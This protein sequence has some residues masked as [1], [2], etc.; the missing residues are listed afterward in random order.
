MTEPPTETPP[1]PKAPAPAPGGSSPAAMVPYALPFALFMALTAA[2]GLDALKP[3]YPLV[4][5]GKAAVVAAALWF[6]RRTFLQ[7][8]FAVSPLA[9]AAGVAGVV[10][11]VGLE[12]HLPYPKPEFLGGAGGEAR[13]GFDPFTAIADPALRW[14]FI[15]VRLIGMAALVPL[16]E[17]ILW[18]GLLIRYI[19]DEDFERVEPGKFSPAAFAVVTVGFTLLH[20]EWL[21]AALYAAGT[22]LV[23]RQTGSLWA[24]IQMHAVTNLLLGVYVLAAGD[25]KFW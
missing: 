10:M 12:N 18:R 20:P 17:E 13:A 8:P 25:R 2:E 3:H 14:A 15:A 9:T 21:P 19:T 1:A 22:N 4:Y 16:M 5:A 11:W 6:C 24:C 23:L 7:F